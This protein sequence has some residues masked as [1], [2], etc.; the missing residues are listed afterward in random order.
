MSTIY[1]LPLVHSSVYYERSRASQSRQYMHIL[2]VR[3]TVNDGSN[4]NETDVKNLELWPGG[5]EEFFS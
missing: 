2:Q 1:A 4:F 3:L 5:C